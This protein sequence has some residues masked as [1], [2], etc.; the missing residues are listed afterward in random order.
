[1]TPF[2]PGALW[3]NRHVQ[4]ILP[5]VLPRR[6]LLS[7][8]RPVREAGREW[9]IECSDGV[10]LQGFHSAPPHPNGRLAVLL[11]GWEGSADA[12]Y[13]LTLAQT[14]FDAGV[15]VLR[16]NLRDHGDTHHLNE[17]IFHSCRL[18]EVVDAI[19]AAAQ[20]W[21]QHQRWLVGFSLGGNFMLR[22][23]ASGD[24]RIGALAG[25][26]AVSPVLDPDQ[27]MLAME[28][29]FPVYQRYFVR[30]WANSLRR[31]QAAWPGKHDFGDLL[32]WRDLRRMT[33]ALVAQHTGFPTM[34]DYL[35]GYAITGSR[36]ATLSAP[37]VIL[38]SEDDP[39]IPAGDLERLAQHPLLEV[40]RMRSGGHMGFMTSPFQRSWVN[41]WILERMGLA[42]D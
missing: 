8:S 3:R 17:G 13:V 26:I 10:K 41:G 23:A 4:S 24:A 22:V 27:A 6:G 1:L 29:G 28:Q 33:A 36:L 7:F 38:A 12:R 15:E 30:K 14:L 2:R 34:K 37:A 42:Q 16:L 20:R 31:K 9:I 39:I 25:V 19:A 35:E 40:V 21:P 11:H 5:S 32:H 18:S